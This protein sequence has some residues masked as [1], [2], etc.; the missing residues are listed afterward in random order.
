MLLLLLWREVEV[1]RLQVSQQGQVGTPRHAGHGGSQSNKN[2]LCNQRENEDNTSFVRK[3]N[4]KSEP[5]IERRKKTAKK[6]PSP[7]H[8]T[9]QYAEGSVQ[10]VIQPVGDERM[11]VDVGC[12]PL[13]PA[14]FPTLRLSSLVRN[15]LHHFTNFSI[16]FNSVAEPEPVGAGTFW[17][18]PEPV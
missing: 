9:L 2:I 6:G 14:H 3:L 11:I 7:K 15:L 12:A 4:K 13:V 1:Y 8:R 5:D 18:E 16:P 10:Y 17:S